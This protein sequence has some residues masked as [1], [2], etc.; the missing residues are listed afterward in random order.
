MIAVE[1]AVDAAGIF[2]LAL[3]FLVAFLWIGFT[4]SW[5]AAAA[6][7]G[8]IVGGAVLVFVLIVG[9]ALLFLSWGWFA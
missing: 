3:G 2:V 5:K 4:D 8:G 9:F 1:S 7:V 6:I